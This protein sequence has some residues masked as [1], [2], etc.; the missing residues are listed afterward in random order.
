MA[1]S[2]MDTTKGYSILLENLDAEFITE[3]RDSM[4]DMFVGTIIKGRRSGGVPIKEFSTKYKTKLRELDAEMPIALPDELK[5]MLLAYKCG[6]SESQI[7][8]VQTITNLSWELPA[9]ERALKRFNNQL[10]TDQKT[11]KFEGKL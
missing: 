10:V 4:W 6:L 5:G 1:T 9:V 7:E 3:K 2:S 11:D 8:N